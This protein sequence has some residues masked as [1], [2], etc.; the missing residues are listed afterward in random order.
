MKFKKIMLVTFLL[1]AVLTIGAVSAADDVASDDLAV[2]DDG[3][4]IESPADDADVLSDGEQDALGDE[5]HYIGVNE[6]DIIID[7]NDPDYDENAT[8]AWIILPND[9]TKGRFV[10]CDG[11]EEIFGADVEAP[12]NNGWHI[13]EGGNLKC[14]ALISQLDLSDVEDEDEIT[15]NFIDSERYEIEGYAVTM[16]IRVTDTTISF[17]ELD[18]DEED[19]I[20]VGFWDEDDERGILYTNSE[21]WVVNVDICDGSEGMIYIIINDDDENPIEWE[22]EC[23]E[24]EDFPYH[25]WSLEDLGIE[26]AGQYNITVKCNDEVIDEGQLNVQNWNGTT[27]RVIEDYDEGVRFL[28]Y[29]PDGAEGTVTVVIGKDEDDEFIIVDDSITYEITSD[30]YN[31]YIEFAMDNYLEE[32][33]DYHINIT[34]GDFSYGSWFYFGDDEEEDD[35]YV[36][37]WDENDERG[38]LYT[39]SEGWVVNVDVCDGSEGMIYII[40]NNDDENPISW[41]IE[42][43][44]WEDFPYHDWSLE[45]LGIEEAGQ[46]NITVKCNDEV[47]DEGQLNVQNWNGTTFRVVEDYDG[48]VRFLLYCPDGAEGTVTVVI[49]KDEDD[50]FIIVYDN[51]TYEITSDDYNDY[52]EF[53]MDNY[54]EEEGDYHINIT[55]GDFSYG[56][57]FYFGEGDDGDEPKPVEVCDIVF[58]ELDEPFATVTVEETEGMVFSIFVIKDGDIIT[59]YSEDLDENER[60]TYDDGWYRL[61]VS[62]NDWN[63]YILENIDD[64]EDI[65]DLFDNGI[66]EDGDS[67]YFAVGDEE[68]RYVITVEEDAYLFDPFVPAE[69]EFYNLEILM[70]D[71]WQY[72]IIIGIIVKDQF[73]PTVVIELNE[74]EVFHELLDGEPDDQTDEG[75]NIFYIALNDLDVDEWEAGEYEVFVE[76]FNGEDSVYENGDEMPY[77]VLYEPQIAGDENTTIEIIPV[78]ERLS[79]NDT[80]I[81]INTTDASKNVTIYIKELKTSIT[82]PLSSCRYDENTNCYLIGSKELGI[83]NAGA[84]DLNVEYAGVNLDGNVSLTSNL[85]IE[86]RSSEDIVYTGEYY[87]DTGEIAVFRL[88]DDEISESDVNGT[89]KVYIYLDGENQTLC[90]EGDLKDLEFHGAMRGRII[91]LTQ[92]SNIASDIE[93][94]YKVYVKYEGGSEAPCDATSNVVFKKLAADDFEVEIKKNKVIVSYN[95]AYWGFIT[96]TADGNSTTYELGDECWDEDSHSYIY[97]LANGVHKVTVSYKLNDTFK[98]LELASKVLNPI[99]P[100][101][102]ISIANI[103]EGADAVIAIT[104]NNTFSGTVLVQIG[105]SNYTVNV[106]NGS[107]TL[108]V[109]GLTAGT[110]NATAIFNAFDVFAASTKNTTFTVKPKVATKITADAVVTTYGTSKNIVISLTAADGTVLSNREVTIVLNGVTKTVKTDAKGQA[111]YSIGNKLAVKA[112]TAT[113]TFAGDANYVKST[114]TVKVTVNKAKPILTA[115]NKSFKVKKSKK[116]T[117]ILKTDKKKAMKNA[118]VVLTGKFKGK[119]IKIIKKTNKK[120]KATFNLK[121][122]TKKGKFK[123]RIKF[124][125]NSNYKAASKKVTIT[126]K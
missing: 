1:L 22:I 50:E 67:L 12:G 74:N 17:Y 123:A 91:R 5:E 100:A 124:A 4:S 46:Y 112:Y 89:V 51:I 42:C 23:D 105:T 96:V 10:I 102:T 126:I 121:K 3:D 19:D 40:I 24:W 93:G 14:H 76:I 92:L 39:D 31:D 30:D 95:P 48:S 35:I 2:S 25:D 117:V 107:G 79:E 61:E 75:Y 118:K 20:Y 90:F 111:T 28:L 83:A 84:Y 32:E 26:E 104:T 7:E 113:L 47:I 87:L 73:D 116:Y 9:T 69:A 56:S 110:Y 63:N 16:G 114:G 38:I 80:L 13:D 78:G 68:Y 52:I 44:E 27:F 59:L 45:D 62:G 21:G 101:L 65:A 94:T 18:D 120:G 125:G 109:S 72:D 119:K 49:G 8:V 85:D 108:P 66:I 53:A 81:I 98:S 57:W 71:D 6:D 115:K 15:F 33:G 58:D 41:E 103:T 37:F 82:I 36:G 97:P 29:C 64:A 54:L 43:D 106:V 88:Y 122:L 99:D 77:L 55:V 11:D 60:V 86:I 34:V 70:K